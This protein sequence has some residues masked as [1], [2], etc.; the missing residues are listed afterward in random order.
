[1]VLW[2][3]GSS[4]R[5]VTA[6]FA[7]KS[8][9]GDHEL[10]AFVVFH[11]PPATPAAYIVSVST[12]SIT[13]ARVRPPTLPGPID[14]HVPSA[15]LVEALPSPAPPPPVPLGNSGSSP[16]PPSPR[17]SSVSCAGGRFLLPRDEKRFIF[18]IFS[19]AS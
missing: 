11:T 4:A 5:T 7:R 13:S 10:P 17:S 1:M 6:M 2:S 9:K 18:L 19:F 14:C 12:G 15:P 8:F 16:P 3:V